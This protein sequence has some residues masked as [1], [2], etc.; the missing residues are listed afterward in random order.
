MILLAL[1]Q[2]L[3]KPLMIRRLKWALLPEMLPNGWRL[4]LQSQ[5]TSLPL[6]SVQSHLTSNISKTSAQL[7][8]VKNS[9]NGLLFSMIKTTMSSTVILEKMM[10]NFPWSKLTSTWQPWIL[11][12]TT[13]HPHRRQIPQ[14]LNQWRSPNQGTQA[15]RSQLQRRHLWILSHRPAIWDLIRL[16]KI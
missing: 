15:S 14:F 7:N 9:C 1:L 3:K 8:T 5:R 11:Q 13:L 16:T 6:K 12:S 4:V 2:F 10:K